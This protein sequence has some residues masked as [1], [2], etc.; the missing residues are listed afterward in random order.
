MDIVAATLPETLPFGSLPPYH[1]NLRLRGAGLNSDFAAWIALR[2][3]T[4]SYRRT[5]YAQP[6]QSVADLCERVFPAVELMHNDSESDCFSQPA[7]LT[8]RT[9]KCN[10]DSREP[11]D[12]DTEASSTSNATFAAVRPPVPQ[13]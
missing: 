9:S 8:V 7:I 4:S 6:A 2:S 13:A 10:E 5:M 12:L 1:T 11:A 3:E